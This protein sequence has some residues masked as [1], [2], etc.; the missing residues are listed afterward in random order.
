M[1]GEPLIA[2]G[3][4]FGLASTRDHR[5]G[6]RARPLDPLRVA[7]LPRLHPDGCVDQ[8]RQLGRRAAG[9]RGTADRD[10]HRGV[11]RRAGHRLRDRRRRRRARRE[12]ADRA[13]R[14]DTGV[15]RGRVP[16]S[17]A[18]PR[19]GARAAGRHERGGR[20]SRARER[21]RR[22]APVCAAAT[23]SPSSIATRFTRRATSS[24]CSRA[25]PPG[26]SCAST[27]SGMASRRRSRSAP[28]SCPT[29]WS[30][31]SCASGWASSSCRPSRAGT[32]SAPCART[33]A[34]RASAS[35]PAT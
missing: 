7:R 19:A 29:A 1:V 34:R 4:P 20:Q 10:Q 3:N 23:W 22:H 15:A 33:A 12:R 18:G 27:W 8:P 9:C 25:S 26:R 2:I 21:A 31:R 17:D 14:G 32:R 5:R 11:Q 28:R 6:L 30:R 16:G 13:R 24:R 35:S